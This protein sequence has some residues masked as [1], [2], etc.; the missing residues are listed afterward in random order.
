MIAAFALSEGNSGSDALAARTLATPTPHGYKL[1]GVKLWVTNGGFVNLLTV[2]AH[3]EGTGFTAFLVERDT[4]GVVVGPEERKMGLRGSSTCRVMFY[5]VFVPAEN[6]LG[7]PGKGHLP[8]LYALNMGRFNIAAIALGAAKKSLQ[9]AVQ[10]ARQRRQ[11]GRAIIEFGL[12]QHKLAEMATRIFLLE[13]VVYRTAGNW[14]ACLASHPDTRA[15]YEEYA[16]ECAI[17][18][19][20]GTEVLGYVVDETLQIHG[21]FGYS[22]DYTPARAYRDARVFRLFEGTNEIN[23]LTVMDQLRRRVQKG[24]LT[25]PA[26]KETNGDLLSQIRIL[27]LS[28][29]AA[30]ENEPGGEQQEV[31]AAFAD[32]AAMLYA[33]ESA[34]LRV[35]KWPTDTGLAAVEVYED[36]A[37]E[38]ARFLTRMVQGSLPGSTTALRALPEHSPVD[39]IRLRRQIARAVLERGGYPW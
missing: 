3:L 35:S 38:E 32:M 21:G 20:F 2:F 7:E 22:E 17:L 4:P 39:T 36:A 11:F 18:K 15:A 16:M 13:S 33:L 5:D 10:Y 31:S 19:F 28:V 25:F 27:L 26:A 12:I 1:N 30:I 8:A 24:R 6:L 37:C 29:L 9:T 23:R 34:C 14:D